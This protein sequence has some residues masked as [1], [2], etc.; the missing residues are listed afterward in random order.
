MV[1]KAVLVVLLGVVARG[2]AMG[3][4]AVSVGAQATLTI[5]PVLRL[6][7]LGTSLSGREIPVSVELPA[8]ETHSA[9]ALELHKVVVLVVRS[10]VPWTVVVRPSERSLPGSVEVRTAG[11]AYRPVR[12][13][14]LVLATGLPGVHEIVLDYRLALGGAGWEGERAL[15]LVYSL[16][17]G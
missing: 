1:R 16:M 13:E 15:T 3:G 6:T 11:G 10:N 9:Q 17:E 12:P 5:P 2:A 14:G 7:C 8:A 4:G